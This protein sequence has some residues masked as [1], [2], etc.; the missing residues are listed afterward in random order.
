[1]TRKLPIDE[2]SEPLG[3]TVPSVAMVVTS[4]A[5]STVHVRKMSSIRGLKPNRLATYRYEQ[6]GYLGESASPSRDGKA[7]AERWPCG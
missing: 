5:R 7:P 6:A 3:Y 2:S 1:M 4:L